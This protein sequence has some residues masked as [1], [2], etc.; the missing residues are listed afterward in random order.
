ML[1]LSLWTHVDTASRIA[2][3]LGFAPPISSFPQLKHVRKAVDQLNGLLSHENRASLAICEIVCNY[4]VSLED[5]EDQGAHISL[6]NAFDGSLDTIKQTYLAHWTPELDIQLQIAKLN[7]YAAS[8]LL[9]FQRNSLTDTQH[10]INREALFLRGLESAMTLIKHMKNM[11]VS[12]YCEGQYP[13]GKLTFLPMHFFTSLFFC[14]AFLFRIF[15]YHQPLGHTHTTRAIQGML[16]AQSIFQLLPLHRG[17]ARAAM[18]IGKFVEKAEPTDPAGSH[19]LLPELIITNRLGASVLWDTFA[20]MRLNANPERSNG[21]RGNTKKR[22]IVGL[23]PLPPAPEMKR[24][25]QKCREELIR[26]P[27]AEEQEANSWAFGDI[28]LDGFGFDF[29]QQIL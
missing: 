8:A 14:T 21:G 3:F 22:R 19:S 10:L 13:A 11:A 16:D 4:S 24:R 27:I 6:T 23:D 18:L 28:D 9:R 12:S 7:L 25:I 15:V 5:V 2:T 20:Q 26:I 1:R 29:N 17:F